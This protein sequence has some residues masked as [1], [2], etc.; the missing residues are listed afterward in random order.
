MRR[1]ETKG[2]G[3]VWQGPVGPLL[4]RL[5]VA[6]VDMVE[7]EVMAW[8]RVGVITVLAEGHSH[9]AHRGTPC[10]VV[11]R[12]RGYGTWLKLTW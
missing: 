9:L 7:V 12:D 2:I 1:R 4:D 11:C 6:D 8:L 5:R 10:V 3:S